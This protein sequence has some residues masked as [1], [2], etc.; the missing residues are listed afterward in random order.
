MASSIVMYRH[1]AHCSVNTNTLLHRRSQRASLRFY[2]SF[3]TSSHHR[4]MLYRNAL[5]TVA[6]LSDRYLAVL[7]ETRKLVRLIPK[8][9]VK[10][11]VFMQICKKS[12]VLSQNFC[13][14]R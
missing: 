7:R 3:E 2:P 10:F 12:E 9:G 14:S 6:V 5:E 13:S 11:S 8:S 1:L 4:P